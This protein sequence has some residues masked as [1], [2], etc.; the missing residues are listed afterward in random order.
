VVYFFFSSR[1]RHTRWPRD[2]IRR[3]LFRSLRTRV[4]CVSGQFLSFYFASLLLV[5]RA[6]LTCAERIQAQIGSDLAEP[7]ALFSFTRSV[8]RSEE[9]RVGKGGAAR[10]ARVW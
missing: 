3:V 1:R 10:G 7:G 8:R 5:E 4:C 9:R 6:A 2:W